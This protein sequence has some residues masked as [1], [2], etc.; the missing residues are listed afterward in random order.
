MEGHVEIY[1][2]NF[3][4]VR[5]ISNAYDL[6]HSERIDMGTIM[7]AKVET[8]VETSVE[9]P[10]ETPVETKIETKVE[11]SENDQNDNICDLLL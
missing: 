6:A 1:P 5:L 10:V 8:S 2:N 9:T 3:D 11:A 7:E 4:I